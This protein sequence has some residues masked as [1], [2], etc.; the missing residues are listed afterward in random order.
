MSNVEY[1]QARGCRK[2]VFCLLILGVFLSAEVSAQET[3]TSGGQSTA[4]SLSGFGGIAWKTGFT[5]VKEHLKNLSLSEN[6]DEKVEILNV[7]ANNYI[8]VKRNDIF[9]R[10]NFYKTPIEIE[11]INNHNI[12]LEEYDQKESLL[13]HVKV[14]TSLL[15]AL[16]VKKKLESIFGAPTKSLINKDMTGAEV[17]ELNGGF[18]FQWQEPLKKKGYTRSID[19]LGQEITQE[20]MKEYEDF[21]DARELYILKKLQLN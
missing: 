14:S 19:Y 5:S 2:F 3:S 12:S 4:N 6:S 11:R 9:Y 21:F 20:I 16:M 7:V 18:V 10:Y 15:D 1:I 17:W 13:Y 8:L